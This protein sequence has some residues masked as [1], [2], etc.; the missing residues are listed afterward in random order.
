KIAARAPDGRGLSGR[1]PLSSVSDLAARPDILKLVESPKPMLHAAMVCGKGHP[2]PQ[3]PEGDIAHEA[4]Q[5]R[6]TYKV[7][8]DDVTVCVMSD[9]VRYLGA[10][11][12]NGSLSD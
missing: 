2:C 1:I 7:S 11:Q 12:K 10:A 4:A 9:S 6:Q 3:D 8:G 5:A